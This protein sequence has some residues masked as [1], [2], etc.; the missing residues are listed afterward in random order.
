MFWSFICDGL[1]IA[2][3]LAI[4]SQGAGEG[5]ARIELSRFLKIARVFVRVGQIASV[6]VNANHRIM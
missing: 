5:K 4:Q 1:L 3:A 6:I 2:P